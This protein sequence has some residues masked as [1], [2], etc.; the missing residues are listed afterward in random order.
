MDV[1]AILF[2]VVALAL[3]AAIILLFVSGGIA[4][5]ESSIGILSDGIPVGN[6]APSCN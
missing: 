4:G 3:M 1:G 2:I 5:L 6:P